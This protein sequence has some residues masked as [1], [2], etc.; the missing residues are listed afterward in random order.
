MARLMVCKEK[1]IIRRDTKYAKPVDV[2]EETTIT[3]LFDTI[4]STTVKI[5]KNNK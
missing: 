3:L 5:F 4:T 1:C 2:N